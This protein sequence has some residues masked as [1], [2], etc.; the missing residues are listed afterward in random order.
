MTNDG[1]P[2]TSADSLGLRTVITDLQSEQEVNLAVV[3]RLV[4]QGFN[5]G[6]IEVVD[7]LEATEYVEH[8]RLAPGVPPTRDAT[9]AI[10][11]DL[12][13]GFPDFHL[14]IEEIDATGDRVWLRMRATGTHRGQFMGSA[15][16]GRRMSVDVMDVV[17]LTGGKI[18]E[19][20]GCPDQLAVLEQLGLLSGD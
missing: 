6:N 12:R 11:Q 18:V 4:E 16:T 20:W 14:A 17:R 5:Q 8:Q 19:H 1:T 9:R 13:G 3:R 7:E 15:P 2:E 10:M